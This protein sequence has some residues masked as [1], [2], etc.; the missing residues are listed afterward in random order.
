MKINKTFKLLGLID[1]NQNLIGNEVLGYKLFGTTDYLKE[2]SY[3]NKVYGVIAIAEGNFRKKIFKK[4]NRVQWE[5]LIH[6]NAMIS[7]YVSIGKGNIICAGV[8]INPECKLGDHVTLILALH[9][10]T[11]FL[12]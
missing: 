10:D 9:S 1:D 8:V 4:L 11:M 5:N 6:P 2:F 7:K 12:C 3:N